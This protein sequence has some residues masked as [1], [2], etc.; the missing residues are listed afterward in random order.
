MTGF[1]VVPVTG[2]VTWLSPSGLGSGWSGLVS[3]LSRTQVPPGPAR[4]VYATDWL[5]KSVVISRA[6]ANA[7]LIEPEIAIPNAIPIALTINERR[8][9]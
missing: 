1:R 7:T 4:G 6:R 9:H 3:G 2:S 8:D 5:S